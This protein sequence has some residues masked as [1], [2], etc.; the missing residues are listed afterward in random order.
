MIRR[1]FYALITRCNSIR[2]YKLP[3]LFLYFGTETMLKVKIRLSKRKKVPVFYILDSSYLPH[4]AVAF[5]LR[6]RRM[7][8][9][10]EKDDCV[11]VEYSR[12]RLKLLKQHAVEFIKYWEVWRKCYLPKFSL[13]GKTVLDVGAGCG[14][15]AMLFFMHGAEK[16]VA[17]E[18]DS[19]AVECLR[20]NIER[21][22]WNVEVIP[23]CFSLEHLKLQFD[24]MKMDCEGC[25]EMLLHIPELNK[26]S[27]IE[28]HKNDLLRQ[29]EGRGWKKICSPTN[30]IHIISNERDK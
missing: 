10:E 24:Y 6:A 7:G 19:K 5:L 30:D 12:V 16:V 15:T 27:V 13:E 26:P 25:E 18:P 23:E 17:V 20:E 28:V 3:F 14:E 8:V 21:N 11:I 29:F 22:K 4:K 1:F 9:I 2:D